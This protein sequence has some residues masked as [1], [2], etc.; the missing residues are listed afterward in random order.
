MRK[1]NP[2]EPQKIIT[3]IILLMSICT[4]VYAQS[5]YAMFGDNSKMLEAKSESVPSI[6]RV[7]VQSTNG[8]SLY[9]DFD[10]NKGLATLYDVEGNKLR[11]DS[12]SEN[13]KAMV[14]TIDPHAESYY[15]LSPYSYCG[16]NPVNRID[17]TGMDWYQNN[18]TS[19]YTWYDGDGA[20]EG[21]THIGGKGS[22]LGEFES[23][24]DRIL[25]DPKGPNLESL[26]SNGFTFDIAPNDK[27]ALIGSKE[28]GWDFFDEFING[29]G[30]E[31]SVL[32]GS[33]PYTQELMSDDVVV[34]AQNQ[35]RRGETDVKGQ[36][37]GVG[38]DW[39]LLDVFTH[40]SL[41]KQFIGSYRYDGYT[42]R[43]GRH[44]NNVVYDSKS[45]TSLGYR[46][47]NE[48]RRSHKSARG[49]TYQFYI[50]QSIK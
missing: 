27:G 33:H 31:F 39:G 24:I 5:P 8:V 4:K 7:G 49:N 16:G 45:N 1:V 23:I 36:I 21:F 28:R 46:L 9:A 6:Y 38:R 13:T 15:H 22:V 32:L 20:R 29:S 35:L 41:A 12:I 2:L 26:Y 19:Y 10:M 37:T 11:Q 14:T 18:Q 44:I 42:S 17:P 3:M 25:T 40:S 48:H 30:P 50:W 34:S 43:D 47:F